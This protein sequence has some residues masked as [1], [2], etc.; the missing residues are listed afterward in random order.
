MK[1]PLRILLS[2]LPLLLFGPGCGGPSTAE[3]RDLFY[4]ANKAYE[5]DDFGKAA[6]DYEKIIALGYENGHIYF[7]LGNAYFRRGETGKAILAYRR[8]ERL[9][10][11][12]PDLRSNL[13]YA[14][15]MVKDELKPPVKGKWLRRIF[16]WYDAMSL[17]ENLLAVVLFNFLFWGTMIGRFFHRGEALRWIGRISLLLLVL[18]TLT[19][20]ARMIEGGHKEGVVTAEKTAVRSGNGTNYTTRFELHAGA[21]FLVEG[22]ED[23]W[24]RIRLSNGERGWVP[25]SEIGLL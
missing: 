17:R 18:L 25:L 24:V 11:R 14:R 16:F 20:G 21:E 22:I 8:A 1:A 10:P 13:S 5:A 4:A 7:N 15:E 19:L 12:D 9:I 3:V 2:A 23:E 6:E